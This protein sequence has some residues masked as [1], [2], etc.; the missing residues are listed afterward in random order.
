M[1]QE[2]KADLVGEYTCPVCTLHELL[3]TLIEG[4]EARGIPEPF[5]KAMADMVKAQ[6]WMRPDITFYLNIWQ[7]AVYDKAWLAKV[8]DGAELPAYHVYVSVCPR[9]G[10]IYASKL[11]KSIGIR[12]TGASIPPA[13]VLPKD[14]Q[15]PEGIRKSLEGIDFSKLDKGVT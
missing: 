9:C 4:L 8:P 12:K 15:L 10:C 7:D 14:V 13:I 1:T 11:E 5:T 3:A 6:G 2:R